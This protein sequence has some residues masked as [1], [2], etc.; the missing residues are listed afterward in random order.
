MKTLVKHFKLFVIGLFCL[1]IAA[2]SILAI[3]PA[4]AQDS[5][6]GEFIGATL[7][8]GTNLEEETNTYNLDGTKNNNSVSTG[9]PQLTILT[10]G[11]GSDASN[12]SN[13]YEFFSSSRKHD[14]N[15]DNEIFSY[16]PDSL[17]EQLRVF[18]GGADVY[19]ARY[20]KNDNTKFF[21]YECTPKAEAFA[22]LKTKDI[23]D[24][25]DADLES[26]TYVP[27]GSPS[28]KELTDISNHIIVVFEAVK[29]WE[30][31]DY[32]Y[33]QLNLVLDKLIYNIKV[34]SNGILP[35][36]NLIGHSRGGITNMQYV[37]D[38]PDLVASVFSMG[39]PYEG[40]K[41]GQSEWILNKLSMSADPNNKNWTQGV[42]DILNEDLYNS[43]RDEWN[44][45]YEKYQHIN[46]HPI[47]G[48]SSLN[49][50]N[51]I[52][53]KD[54]FY[55]ADWLK[56]VATTVN[57]LNFEKAAIFLIKAG[58]LEN[59]IFN[60]SDEGFWEVVDILDDIIVKDDWDIFTNEWTVYDD[61]FINVE[62]QLAYGYEGDNIH[63]EWRKFNIFEGNFDK[64]A[65]CNTPIVHN[66]ETR[67]V[68]I[69]KYILA[70]IETG[71]NLEYMTSDRENN[72]VSIEGYYGVLPTENYVIPA[73]IKNKTVSSIGSYAYAD[74]FYNKNITTVTIPASVTSIEGGA[75]YGCTQ[76]ENVIFETGSKL[77]SIGPEAFAGCTN[78][79]SITLPD[80]ITTISS[81]AFTGCSSL[82]NF[83]IGKNVSNLSPTAFRGCTSLTSFSVNTENTL[84][85]S[86]S[87]VLFSKDLQQL[88][89]YPLGKSSTT[90]TL[91]NATTEILI[92]AF[93]GNKYLTTV[94]LNMTEILRENAFYGCSNLSSITGNYVNF[95]EIDALAET[96]WYKNNSSSYITL[97]NALIKYHGSENEIEL[98]DYFSISEFAFAFNDNILKVII[99]DNIVNIGS[100]AF[101]GCQNLQEVQLLN[102]NNIIFIGDATFEYNS[103]N[104]K[105]Y[106]PQTL[107][108]EY[109]SND[110][111]QLYSNDIL[112]HETNITFD[113]NGGTGNTSGSVYYQDYLDLPDSTR[114]GYYLEGWY[115]NESLE[116]DPFNEQTPW[117]SMDET[118]TFYAKWTPLEYL[119]TYHTNGGYLNE[120]TEIYTV[121]NAVTYA[122]PTKTGFTFAGWYYDAGLTQYAGTGFSAGEIGD[123]VLYA[124]WSGNTYTIELDLNDDA[125]DPASA[126][127]TTASVIFNQNFTL[128]TA[129]RNGYIFNGW[130]TADGELYTLENGSSLKPWDIAQDTMLYA[131]W[132]RKQF[133][134]KVNANGTISWLGT[135]GFSDDQTPIEYGSEFMTA[136]EIEQAFNPEKISYKDGHKFTY[137]TLE[138]GTKFTSWTEVP[139]LGPD[140]TIICIYANYTPEIN[141]NIMFRISQGE[142]LTAD[143]G[144]SISLIPAP[145]RIGYTFKYWMVA[146]VNVAPNNSIYVGT[147]L[148]P[149]TAFNYTVMPDLSIGVEEDGR[150]IVL[151]AYYEPNIYNVSFETEYVEPPT[152]MSVVYD[153]TPTLPVLETP[154]RTFLGWYTE[155][156]GNGDQITN[157]EGTLT[158]E[159]WNIASDCTLYAAWDTEDYTIT[160]Y[161]NGGQY[162]DGESN[163]TSYTI[164]TETFELVDPVRDGYRFMGWYP[165]SDFS[166]DRVYSIPQGSYE[167]QSL[168]AQWNKLYLLQFSEDGYISSYR[169]IEG[170]YGE[171]VS[172][173][174][175]SNKGY[176][177]DGYEMGASYIITG[178]RTFYLT[179]KSMPEVYNSSSGYYE[180][181]T[182]NQLNSIRNYRSSKHMLMAS[183]TMPTTSSWTPIPRFTGTFDGNSYI[184][185]G[186]TISY[187]LSSPTT[188]VSRSTYGLFEENAWTIK[189]LT[190][191]Q[192]EIA[193]YTYY[194]T[195]SN[196]PVYGGLIAAKNTGTISY[197]NVYGSFFQ[198]AAVVAEIESY[199]GAICGY[200]TGRIEYC[201][202]FEVGIQLTTGYGGGIVGHNKGGTI[203]HCNV[204]LSTVSCYQEFRNDTEDGYTADHYAAAGGI[205]GYAEGGTISYCDVAGDVDVAYNGFSSESRSLAPELGIIAGRSTNATTYIANVADGEI[206]AING[207]NV[208][209]WTTG[210]LWWKEEHSW[211][212]A[213]YAK[214][215]NVGRYV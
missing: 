17:I 146:D 57:I 160:Y 129:T 59:D 113:H 137:F 124:K 88:V 117:N 144:E 204:G 18:S 168:Y 174:N 94:N 78:L 33:D 93:A 55:V 163:P 77:T 84:F 51:K 52:I 197:C 105:I 44:N 133:Y 211:D 118:V 205:V 68:K 121:E 49:F 177:W 99:D 215:N 123:K 158:S 170:I 134:V 130:A 190:L 194:A 74:N 34:L 15:A 120:T 193:L 106:V 166:E 67:D 23:D 100:L 179:E 203:T 36:I 152:T 40:S 126:S 125:K 154:G 192:A 132:T 39:A 22:N 143:Y 96:Y 208:I 148:A 42:E 145:D 6:T 47:A 107:Y 13:P 112:V 108:N 210:A 186:M 202:A 50:V 35:R 11:Y 191:S 141:F 209:K 199:S 147:H 162:A 76:L 127:S 149:G 48:Y 97:G 21:L 71:S 109:L 156:D 73:T 43:Y 32:I 142:L 3:V 92:N 81:D 83:T 58:S 24:I 66:L 28:I 37:L 140:G 85:T 9:I 91:P 62:S 188:T 171:T 70:N 114:D 169:N 29:P 212:Q 161:L 153:S 90:Y 150:S 65:Q 60:I 56:A 79:T 89:L 119:I 4:M 184:I 30:G 1:L 173:P 195:Y 46:F 75:F 201:E 135:D 155:E 80:S 63:R 176:T 213:Q 182:Y 164:D 175:L 159:R 157:D 196:V 167:D 198:F 189:N 86:N 136:T 82:S 27:D 25:T 183:I 128:P 5:Y 45:N 61:L 95:V 207:L 54:E 20:E 110:F 131:N 165:D 87:G 178:N 14:P 10:H 8:L 69:I 103:E 139:D 41:L 172:L 7:P 64:V 180:I 98:K 2:A 26:I 206:S 116:G 12:W 185:S 151:D 104:R 101:Y 200:N 16:D 111:W 115:D 38:H 72:T 181:W 19:L 187:G 138:D 102:P 53:N 31:N 122:I 214:G